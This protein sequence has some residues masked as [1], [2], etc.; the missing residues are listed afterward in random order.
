MEAWL[1]SRGVEQISL[2]LSPLQN[3]RNDKAI[4]HQDSKLR[5]RSYVAGLA[6]GRHV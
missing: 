6:T 5:L 3:E 1:Y 2:G 4:S